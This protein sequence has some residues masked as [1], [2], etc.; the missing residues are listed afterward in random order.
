MIKIFSILLILT[1]VK[2]FAQTNKVIVVGQI[3]NSMHNG[4]LTGK[5]KLDTIADKTHIYGMGPKE[6]FMG[7]VLML[8]GK[9]YQSSVLDENYMFIEE[10]FFGNSPFFAYANIKEW[11]EIKLPAKVKN[12]NQLEIFLLKSSKKINQPFLFRI[13]GKFELAKI[14]VVNLTPGVLIKKPEDA[15]IGKVTY[16]IFDKD[17]EILGF[18]STQHQQIFTHHNA[19]THMHLITNDKTKM[20]HVDEL[21]LNPK[22]IK[23]YFPVY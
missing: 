4:D 7:E 1:S 3:K 20:G 23:L 19:Y 6:Y 11:K 17:A 21:F 22:Q 13:K 16:K 2:T 15:E 18:F 5:I 9:C 10:G 14:H 12:I 8:D